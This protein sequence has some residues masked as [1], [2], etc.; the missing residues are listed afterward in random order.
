M[1]EWSQGWRQP[2]ILTLD[3]ATRCT[4]SPTG[5]DGIC[6]SACVA[7]ADSLGGSRPARPLFKGGVEDWGCATSAGAPVLISRGQSPHEGSR[8]DFPCT[9]TLLVK[10]NVLYFTLNLHGAKME[11]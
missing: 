4:L 3:G 9:V 6:P 7:S 11:V 5:A 2:F 10:Y 8:G 1:R